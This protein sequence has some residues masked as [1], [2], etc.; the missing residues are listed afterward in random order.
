MVVVA[1]TLSL[2]AHW[3]AYFWSTLFV[4][5]CVTA[6]TVRLPPLS[7]FSESKSVD[8]FNFDH[9]D[10][11]NGTRL[12]RAW[13]QAITVARTA[14]PIGPMAW[15]N[16]VDG[17]QMAMRVVPSILSIGMLGLLA[18]KYTPLFDILGIL[19]YPVAWLSRLQDP[20]EFSSALSSGL[21]EMFLPAIQS[22]DMP[23]A[24]R[25][26]V[27][28]VSVSSILFFSASI[29]C[30][31]ATEIPIKIWQ[32]IIVWLERT[33]IAVPMAAALGYVFFP[34]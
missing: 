15:G 3:N 8:D 20:A 30:V 12:G 26:A 10:S 5:F 28:I 24:T 9:T 27:G 31:L 13:Q 25:F 4:T 23:E 2:S 1:N 17:L 29:P 19:I 32:L 22:T 14:G 33:I 6:I 21:A 18:A 11:S 7:T 34:A 16:L